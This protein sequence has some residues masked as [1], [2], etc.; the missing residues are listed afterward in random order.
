[1]AKLRNEHFNT[2]SVGSRPALWLESSRAQHSS[3][4]LHSTNMS[5]LSALP[6]PTRNDKKRKGEGEGKKQENVGISHKRSLKM[7]KKLFTSVRKLNGHCET[8]HLFQKENAMAKA[9]DAQRTGYT[10]ATPKRTSDKKG[11]P[12]PWGPARWSLMAVVIEQSVGRYQ[13]S[14]EALARA[15]K[16]FF[17]FQE[18]FD[19]ISQIAPM[20][21][22][23]TL[24]LSFMENFV[25]YMETR[26]TK[27]GDQI[28]H[29]RPQSTVLSCE[30][31]EKLNILGAD[32]E[33]IWHVICHPIRGE[34]KTG[35][36]PMGPD[37]R[38][39]ARLIKGEGEDDDEDM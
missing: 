37:E 7:M 23:K 25:A 38:L 11:V 6:T 26:T 30:T 24:E 18:I 21:K 13:N 2:K 8:T 22:A 12:H 15:K 31:A 19:A 5:F 32:A 17:G 4:I 39:L 3:P 27:A 36:A 16:I 29:T 35:L 10:E 14:P 20:L 34:Q 33:K 1:M 9:L 28:L